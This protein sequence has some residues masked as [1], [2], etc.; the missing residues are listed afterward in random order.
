MLEGRGNIPENP[1]FF[2]QTIR[3]DGIKIKNRYNHYMQRHFFNPGSNHEW[4]ALKK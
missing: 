4:K 1:A 3:L 2:Q